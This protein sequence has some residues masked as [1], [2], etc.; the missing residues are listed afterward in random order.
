MR[1]VGTARSG[2]EATGDQFRPMI[3]SDVDPRP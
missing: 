2:Y 1:I 3:N